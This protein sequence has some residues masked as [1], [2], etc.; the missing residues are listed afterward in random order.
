MSVLHHASD[1]RKG[2]VSELGWVYL[3]TTVVDQRRPLFRDFYLGR[4][5]V[6]ALRVEHDVGTVESLAWV[7][8]PDHLHWLICLRDTGL[9]DV[10]RRVKS[11]SAVAVNRAL[12]ARGR[13]WQKGYY[14]HAARR[15][16]DLQAMARYVVANPVRAGLVQSVR[17]YPLW[18]AVWV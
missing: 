4:L 17:E 6:T 18:D 8:M 1:L 13:V 14:D 12:E 2:R 7:L 9:E 5:V 16:E 3:V 15:D 11:R 10:M